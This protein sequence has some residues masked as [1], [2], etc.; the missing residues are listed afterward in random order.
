MI[1]AYLSLEFSHGNL[2][3]TLRISKVSKRTNG[4]RVSKMRGL[5]EA[6]KYISWSIYLSST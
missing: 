6:N 3:Y 4:C 5:W 2:N 1:T